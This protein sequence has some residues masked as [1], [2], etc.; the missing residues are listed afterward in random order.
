MRITRKGTKAC[1]YTHTHAR[2]RTHA[3]TYTHMSLPSFLLLFV[4]VCEK[5]ERE[6]EMGERQSEKGRTYEDD[7]LPSLLAEILFLKLDLFLIV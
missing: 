1:P 7:F 2:T 6:K 4:S 5:Y 3:L